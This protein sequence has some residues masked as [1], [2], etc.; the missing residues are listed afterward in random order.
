MENFFD[1]KRIFASVWKWKF[2]ISIAIL[3]AVVASAIISGPFFIQPKFKSSARIY[4]FNITE[5]SEESESEHLLEFLQTTDIKFRVIDAFKLDEV[6]KINRNEKLYQT[7]ILYE[8]NKN[9]KFKKTDFEAIEISALDTDPQRAHDIVDSIIIFLNEKINAEKAASHMQQAKFYRQALEK[10]Y[11]E[12]DSIIGIIDSIR[13]KSGLID[14]LEQVE[15][16]TRGLMDASAQG[17]DRKPATTMIESFIDN[18]GQ[19]YKHQIMLENYEVHADT[20]KNRH[21][22]HYYLATQQAPYTKTV[23]KPFVADKKAYP[24]RWL[25]VF[26]STIGTAF[27]SV[28]TVSLI[29][30][31]RELKKSV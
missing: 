16:V 26:L 29:D 18:G 27:V 14:Y 13:E 24:I 20:L 25:I 23:E 8:F 31:I 7:W 21:D 4:P 3:I 2:H 12:I 1:N 22:K 9:I 5:M 6:Y 30:Y 28:I 17:G 10:K 19:L 11:S 15:I